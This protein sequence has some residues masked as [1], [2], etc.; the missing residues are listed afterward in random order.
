M[1]LDAILEQRLR[2]E[3]E[4]AIARLLARCF[5]TD[6]GGRSYFYQRHHLRLIWREAGTVCAHMAMLLRAV[7]LGEAVITVGG[8]ADVATDP[9]HRGKGLA[10]ALIAAAI[11]EARA[12]GVPFLLL[13]GEAGLYAGAGFK[14]QANPIRL[15]DLRG[16]QTRGLRHKSGKGLMVLTLGEQD[17]EEQAV[18]D[19]LGPAF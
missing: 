5:A 3:D 16:M 15:V 6:F 10:A 7:R 4:T 18:L 19:L 1:G 2:P 8:L 12:A 14:A 9:D 17:W 13:F 11:A